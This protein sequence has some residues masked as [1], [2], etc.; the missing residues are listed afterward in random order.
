MGSIV[1]GA[2]PVAA[3]RGAAPRPLHRQHRHRGEAPG[4]DRLVGDQL[5]LISMFVRP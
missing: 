2:V 1:E 5:I 3:A 4:A